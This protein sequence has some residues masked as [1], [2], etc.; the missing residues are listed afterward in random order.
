MAPLIASLLVLI[1][2]VAAG[3]FA[4]QQVR[5]LS[6]LGRTTNLSPQD[7]RYLRNQAWRRLFGCVLLV[8]VGVLMTWYYVGGIDAHIDALGEAREAQ[9]KGGPPLSA[10]QEQS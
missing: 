5:L 2:F 6:G 10:E 4:W 1:V 3:F 8:S 7:Y 9:A